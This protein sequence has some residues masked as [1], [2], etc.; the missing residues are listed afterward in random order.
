MNILTMADLAPREPR[1]ELPTVTVVCVDG[2]DAHRG[3]AVLERCQKLCRF[4]AVKLLTHLPVDYP[5]RVE[6]L[7]LTSIIMYSIFMLKRL[8]EFIDTSHML[9]V[10]H[11]GWVLNPEAWDPAWLGYDYVAPLYT[12]Y[13]HVGSGGFSLRTRAMMRHVSQLLPDWDPTPEGTAQLQERLGSYEDG[14]ISFVLHAALQGAGFRLAPPMAGARF[15]QAGNRDPA[16][17][18]A[19]PFGFHGMWSEVDHVAGLVKPFI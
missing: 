2:V 9:V 8:H 5:H 15:A 3:A 6:I 12:Q 13:P 7:P 1:L 10:Q 14:V 18:V 4:G 19:R 11:D 16:Y 17:Q